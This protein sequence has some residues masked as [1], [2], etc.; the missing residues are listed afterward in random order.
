MISKLVYLNK[1]NNFEI[2]FWVMLAIFVLWVFIFS[3]PWKLI[4]N[5]IK[6]IQERVK[7]RSF[8]TGNDSLE[9]YKALEILRK[10]GKGGTVIIERDTNL[11]NYVS[12]PVNLN[13]ILSWE[14]I[15]T[16]FSSNK[17]PLHDGAI[18]IRN[19]K[20]KY[21]SSYINFLSSNSELPSEFGTRHRS[22]IGI[23]EK[24]DS[25]AIILSE[26]T[27]NITISKNGKYEQVTITKFTSVLND[28][29]KK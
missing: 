21:A 23:T 10:D 5:R 25:I 1:I 16:I 29:L 14:L 6:N 13:A 20:I 3:I 12:E 7:T 28:R 4:I 15:V 11:D 17:S 24:T 26:E 19:H 2:A 27:G 9:I 8:S 18:I 22:A